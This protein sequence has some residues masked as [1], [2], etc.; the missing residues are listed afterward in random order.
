MQV[1]EGVLRKGQESPKQ[2]AVLATVAIATIAL[3]Y[4]VSGASSGGSGLA[5]AIEED[6]ARKIMK[7]IYAKLQTLAPR[8]MSAAQNIKQ[9]IQQSG[10]EIDDMTLMRQFI[11]PHLD[12]NFSDIQ[13]SVLEEFDV[14]VDE[15]E[16]AV[17]TYVEQGDEELVSICK[18]IRQ[19][20]RQFGGEA[21]DD[22]SSAATGGSASP[23][24][25][26]AAKLGPTEVVALMEELAKQMLQSTD[27]Y[28]AKFIDEHGVPKAKADLETFQVGLLQLSQT[29][30]K[31]VL[32]EVGLTEADLQALLMAN[33]D[34]VEIQQIFLGMQME[35]QKLLSKHGISMQG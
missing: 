32:S 33:Q 5:P 25:G 13:N 30:E 22:S 20:Y 3:L 34:N 17:D 24:A 2:T 14:E 11:L 18:G 16:E 6:E 8:L 15:L 35:N 21:D 27:D 23:S 1:V 26:S 4:G 19:L 28:C 9:Q 12:T 7:S 29:V 31:A 10:Q